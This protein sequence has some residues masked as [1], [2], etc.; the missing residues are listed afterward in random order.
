MASDA[1]EN[2]AASGGEPGRGCV[3]TVCGCPYARWVQPVRLVSFFFSISFFLIAMASNL[4]ASLLL[5]ATSSVLATSSDALVTN[6]DGL[7]PSS[8]LT[9]F[10]F[11]VLFRSTGNG[12]R[13]RFAEMR[14]RAL[15]A[16][17]G[18]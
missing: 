17:G 16:G 4:I 18:S 7:Q 11:A 14:G 9:M 15:R 1:V 2:A 6:S 3:H 5:V 13:K 10:A 12:R 8:T